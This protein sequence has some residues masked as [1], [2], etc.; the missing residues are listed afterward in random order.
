MRRKRGARTRPKQLLLR[1]PWRQ[2]EKKIIKIK[3]VGW[4]VKKHWG[5]T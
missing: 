3:T 5:K 1:Q 4:G 2:Q